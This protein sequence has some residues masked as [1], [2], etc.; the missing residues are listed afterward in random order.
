MNRL[1]LHGVVVSFENRT[2]LDG[3]TLTVPEGEF[4]VIIGPNGCGKSTL[5]RTLGRMLQPRAGRVLLDRCDIRRLRTRDVA[6]RIGF[7]P[8]SPVVPE[9]VTVADLVT[10]GRHPHQ[11]I[12][13]RWSEADEAAVDEALRE[14]GLRAESARPVNELSGGQR[15]RAWIA[16]VLAQQTPVLLLDE[17]T[18]YLDISHQLGVLDLCSRLHRQGRTLVVVLHDLN[19]AARYATHLIALRGGEVVAQG[20]PRDVLTPQLLGEV[21]DLAARIVTDPETCGPLVIPRDTRV[22]SDI[23]T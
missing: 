10:R 16:M 23:T 4:T 6:R 14:V 13:S 2:I 17:P 21:F 12:F 19:L 11:H 5:L 1:E 22:S 8:Q 3:L 18:T 7:L 15:Q 20:S 9:G